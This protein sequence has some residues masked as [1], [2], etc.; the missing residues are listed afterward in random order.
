MYEPALSHAICQVAQ[1]GWYLNGEML[2]TFEHEFA[3]YVGCDYCVG[4]GNGLDAL[5]LALMAMKWRE[6]WTE[7]AEVVVPAMTFVATA[8]A[9]VR[10]GLRPVLAD[11]DSHG[12]MT[13]DT[14]SRVLTPKTCALLPVHLYGHMAPMGELMALA[15]QHHL[16]VLEDAAQAHGA[17][18]C[19]KKAGHWGHMA[20]F[21]FYPGKNLGALGDAGAVCT[22]DEVLA[23]RVRMLANYGAERK[24]H[25]EAMGLN[26]RM[27]EIQAAVLS[28][29]LPHLDADN[30]R[31]NDLARTYATAICHPDVT[32]PEAS[33]EQLD[34]HHIYAIRCK[35]RDALQRHLAEHG[36]QTLIHYPFSLA[37][38]PALSPWIPAGNPDTLWPEATRWAREE[39]SLPISPVQ[40][41]RSGKPVCYLT[42]VPL[43]LFPYR[44]MHPLLQSIT[45]KT[46]VQP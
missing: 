9:V 21:S 36:V 40:G 6:R 5:T 32:L 33:P 3:R 34:V 2:H 20:A 15:Q 10:A 27:D 42:K 29:K 16:L 43:R 18:C 14:A 44:N 7:E 45:S 31:R 41:G 46:A 26:S 17:S 11:V 38:Q 19:G 4:V 39:L 24:Y 22:S 37:E 12:V 1:S 8:Q 23:R 35:H 28:V 13:A 25:H 30:A